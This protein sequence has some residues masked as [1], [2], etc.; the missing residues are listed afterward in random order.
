MPRRAP[1]FQP[2]GVG[3]PVRAAS[4][5][6]RDAFYSSAAWMR[7]RLAF[8]RANPVCEPCLDGGRV[9]PATIAHHLVERLADPARALDPTNLRAMCSSCHSLHHARSATGG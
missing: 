8:L 1:R 9:E 5:A 4:K 3:R 2:P 6:E 7:L